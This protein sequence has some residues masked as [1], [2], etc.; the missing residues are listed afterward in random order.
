MID[1]AL[2]VRIEAK[3]AVH[4]PRPEP[5]DQSR[6]PEAE[7]VDADPCR[8]VRRYK[9]DLMSEMVTNSH[10]RTVRKRPK[11]VSPEDAVFC[12]KQ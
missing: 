12:S 3:E 5:A 10:K 8:E 6:G 4:A 11:P 1:Q 2:F 9:S 7:S